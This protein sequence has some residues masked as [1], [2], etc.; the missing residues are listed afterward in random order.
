MILCENLYNFL[1]GVQIMEGEALAEIDGIGM[2]V[3]H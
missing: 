3:D 2:I 1:F